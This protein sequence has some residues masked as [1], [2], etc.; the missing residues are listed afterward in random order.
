MFGFYL[1]MTLEYEE[2]IDKSIICLLKYYYDTKKHKSNIV[3]NFWNS[4]I[5]QPEVA[6]DFGGDLFDH[7]RI[8]R[9][10]DYPT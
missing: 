10:G 5:D 3:P 1:G 7:H 4:N 9:F 6:V 8:A 2:T